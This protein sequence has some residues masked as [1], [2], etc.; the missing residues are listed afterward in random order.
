MQTK[1]ENERLCAVGP[2]SAMGELFRRYWI[3]ACLSS[4]LASAPSDPLPLRLLGEDLVAFRDATG[5][6]GILD[7]YCPHRCASLALGHLEP[8]GLRCLYHGWKVG[9]DG[10]ILD[11]PNVANPRFRESVKAR[12]YPTYERGDIVWVYM[13]PSGKLPAKPNYRF[14]NVDPSHRHV[15]RWSQACSYLQVLEGGLDSSHVGILHRDVMASRDVGQ[16]MDSDGQVSA[17]ERDPMPTLEVEDTAFGFHYC[18]LRRGPTPTTKQARVTPFVLPFGRVIPPSRFVIFE[19]PED[20]THTCTVNVILDE[21]KEINP[22]EA[23][24]VLGLDDDRFWD[25]RRLRIS[26]TLGFGQDREAMRAERSFSGFRGLVQEDTAVVLS[27]GPVIDR[28]KEHVVPSDRAVV[29]LR[30]LLLECARKVELGEDPPGL[31]GYDADAISAPDEIIPVEMRWQ[32]LVPG[33]VGLDL[34]GRVQP[35]GPD[36]TVGRQ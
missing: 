23:L 4:E 12:A 31:S 33:H 27:M 16:V 10:T 13:G 32:D 26:R 19:V 35:R 14:M 22:V 20:D 11:T 9:V 7:E 17:V 5:T 29:R 1:E 8:D 2:G 3:P 24:K 18:A 15:L 36:R 6:V 28:T 30:R 34:S 21:D 25:G